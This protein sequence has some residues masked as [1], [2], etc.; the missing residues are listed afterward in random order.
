MRILKLCILAGALAAAACPGAEAALTAAGAYALDGSGAQR[1][2]FTNVETIALRQ[3]VTNTVASDSMIQFTFTIY[4]P[5]GGAVF[6]HTGNSTRATLGNSN[7][8]LSG[9]AISR[10][11]SSPGVYNFR[12]EATLDG[13]TVQQAL[14]PFQI[15][16][17]NI[18]LIY[19]PNGAAGLTD[20]P[21]TFRWVASGASN[22]EITVG[23][24]GG[25]TQPY[26][27]SSSSAMFTYPENP[28]NDYDKLGSKTYQWKVR[29]LDAG[30]A[31]I[32]E[33][34]QYTFSMTSQGASGSRNVAVTALELT[35][36]IPD[37]AQPLHFSVTVKN[38]GSSNENTIGVKLSLGGLPSVDP[39]GNI[40][41]G[42]GA[43]ANVKFN[44]F[45]PT[46]QTEGLAI[47][48]IDL[49]D[50]NMQDNCKTKLISKA[51]GPGA[52]PE[53]T[54]ETRSLSYQEIWEEVLKRLGPDVGKALEGYTFDSIECGNCSGSELNDMML[55]LVN[56]DAQL[57]GAAVTESFQPATAAS[58]AALPQPEE[59]EAEP[60]D[61]RELDVEI[62]ET[63]EKDREWSGYTNAVKS[64]SPFFYTVK[65]VKVWRKVWEMLSSEEAPK[66]DFGEKTVIGVIA[67]T[68]N[69]ADSVRII[70]RRQVG[71]STVFDYYMT[72]SRGE[73]P[74]VPYIFKTFD[75]VEG[76]VEF[77]RLD[78]GGK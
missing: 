13:V 68:G 14:V 48:C 8:Q 32:A 24:V 78:V 38:M 71:E 44:A 46:G 52:G 47:A 45:M 15:S 3:V 19:P 23:Q 42:A 12:G 41:L 63:G 5:S 62:A 21:L 17:P 26:K 9:L 28:P 40:D 18:N 2:T 60:E 61:E 16:S 1:T 51:S 55:A 53:G 67:G 70:S 22:Y 37:F 10:F 25:L 29:G 36:A 31:V 75:K 76:K 20:K 11:Y 35:D 27:G 43:S 66:V 73:N 57:S 7:S 69:K 77:K 30:G 6:R 39:A 59:R 50:E 64:P 65:S 56:G 4:N 58:L 34:N 33:S 54:K 49:F 74:A 72:E